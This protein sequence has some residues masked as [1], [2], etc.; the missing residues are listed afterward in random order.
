MATNVKITALTDIGSNISYATLV[1][2]VDMSGVPVT[3]KANLQIVG[4]LIL[5]AAG[6]VNFV[7]AN[8]ASYAGNVII[9]AQPNITSVGSL[10][11]L[12]VTGN[13]SAGNVTATGFTGILN[14][15]ATNAAT[16]T[17]AAQPNITS[18]GPM[19]SL[20]VVGSADLGTIN[21][22]ATLFV[23]G[24]ANVGNLGTNGL[25]VAVGS[26]IG[27]SLST[28]GT[29]SAGDATVGN[30]SAGVGTFSGA[31]TGA[32][33]IIA[34][35]N[36]AGGNLTTSGRITATG[37]ANVG[38]IGATAGVFTGAVTAATTIS[39]TGN[40]SG[41]NLTTTGRLTV[42][43]NAIVGNLTSTEGAFS[44]NLIVSENI[45]S[46][47]VSG[48]NAVFT[49]EI[50]VPKITATTSL[51]TGVYAST[52]ARDAAIPS[53]AAGMIIFLSSTAKFQGFTGFAWS[54]LN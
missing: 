29:L 21:T 46:G 36:V 9:A 19:S 37:N 24:D 50:T 17:N 20:Y 5:G 49:H 43:G 12:T 10:L 41:G 1:P 3:D 48:Y 26:V 18:V 44:G 47:N 42:T 23:A 22:P 45:N 32:I 40:V 25:V 52:G 7:P 6:G 54:D 53:P 35:G 16:V 11:S 33:T 4:N 27:G 38:N 39:A 30:L 8:R 28:A 51:H 2:V 31:I 34:T 15:P 14:G 13:V